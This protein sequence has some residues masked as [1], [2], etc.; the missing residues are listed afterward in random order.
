MRR[1]M[2]LWRQ[3]RRLEDRIGELS[4]A[5]LHAEVSAAKA[6]LLAI[7]TDE[8]VPI[9]PPRGEA[10]PGETGTSGTATST[11]PSTV[12]TTTSTASSTTTTTEPVTST[13]T[14]AP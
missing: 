4:A 13:T 3:L 14:A 1:L 9:G 10:P 11:V 8:L 12:S 6:E 2:A 5:Q 7:F